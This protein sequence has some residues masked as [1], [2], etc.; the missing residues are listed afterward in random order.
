[1][2]LG[3]G[4]QA[5]TRP[6]PSRPEISRAVRRTPRRRRWRAS[7]HHWCVHRCAT[8]SVSSGPGIA[9]QLI[10]GCYPFGHRVPEP[11]RAGERVARSIFRKNQLCSGLKKMLRGQDENGRRRHQAQI[12][13]GAGS[14]AGHQMSVRRACHRRR[15]AAQPSKVAIRI[16]PACICLLLRLVR[17]RRLRRAPAGGAEGANRTDAAVS[18]AASI[19]SGWSG[20]ALIT[21]KAAGERGKCGDGCLS[22]AA[23][24]PAQMRRSRAATRRSRRTP[25]TACNGF[26]SSET[27]PWRRRGTGGDE[28]N[29]GYGEQACRDGIGRWSRSPGSSGAQIRS[30]R[31][32]DLVEF[33]SDSG[34][35]QVARRREHLCKPPA[36]TCR[37]RRK[38]AGWF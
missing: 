10:V 36:V 37:R 24:S 27:A 17:D 8:G 34:A 14:R 32:L 33:Q 28:E 15:V 3:I 21:P 35:Q 26:R 13:V 7:G 23:A 31:Q 5:R 9:A 30:R 16:R 22:L 19:W 11:V 20:L 4:E 38:N 1:M 6:A 2:V 25:R 18:R 29:A 12:V